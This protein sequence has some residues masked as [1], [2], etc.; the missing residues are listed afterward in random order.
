MQSTV[1]DEA[2]REARVWTVPNVLSFLRL[3]GVPLFL[4]LV[5][6]PQADGWA[7]FVLAV[8]SLTDYL[9]GKI[10]RATGQ[11]IPLGRCS[12]RSPTA[13]TSRR[14]RDGLAHPRHHPLV[15]G[16]PAACCATSC[17]R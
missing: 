13:R 16:R 5:L 12:T 8:S 11:T 3:L 2:T 10:A 6:G 17:S 4:W 7:L 15:A 9:D 1:A 14:G